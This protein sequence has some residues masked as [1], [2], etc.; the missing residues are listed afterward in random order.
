[1]HRFVNYKQTDLVCS[2]KNRIGPYMHRIAKV[3]GGG[4]TV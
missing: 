1:M 3:G 4:M 2:K